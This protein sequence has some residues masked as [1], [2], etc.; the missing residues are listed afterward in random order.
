MR[1]AP[2]LLACSLLAMV[3]ALG[4]GCDEYHLDAR[5]PDDVEG[6]PLAPA[7]TAAELAGGTDAAMDQAIDEWIASQPPA[8]PPLPPRRTISFGFIGDAPLQPI[9]PVEDPPWAH[10]SCGQCDEDYELP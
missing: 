7:S 2:R 6:M 10:F 1:V 8:P 5:S 4:T 3:L 9:P